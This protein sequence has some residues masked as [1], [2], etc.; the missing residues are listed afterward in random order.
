MLARIWDLFHNWIFLKNNGKSSSKLWKYC[1]S[2]WNT[3]KFMW[4]YVFYF[5][6]YICRLCNTMILSWLSYLL[7]K[8]PLHW[9]CSK[10]TAVYKQR[11][12]WKLRSHTLIIHNFEGVEMTEFGV[13]F[14]NFFRYFVHFG[15]DS[16]IFRQILIL[17]GFS[18]QIIRLSK[19]LIKFRNIN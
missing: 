17:F 9:Y 15:W 7:W 5:W 11:H 3:V 2:W 18:L 1:I 6:T 19:L 12:F 10:S 16:C 4:T 8:W 13:L 14:I